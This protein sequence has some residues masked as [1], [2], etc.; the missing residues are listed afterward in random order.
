MKKILFLFLTSIA[1]VPCSAQW[2]NASMGGPVL[3]FGVH[4]TSLFLSLNSD[5]N[6]PQ[7]P[8]VWR[9]VS[10]TP[11]VVWVIADTGIDFSQG[12]VTSF[13]SLGKYFFAGQGS[14]PAN[15]STNNGSQWVSSGTASP[16]ATNGR[17]LFAQYVQPSQIVRST[18]SGRSW[19]AKTNLSVS[20]YA[21]IGIVIFANN[22]SAIWRSTDT[23]NNWSQIHPPFTG[24][25]TPMDSLLFIV[26]SGQLAESND[27][28]TNWT[29]VPVDSGGVSETVNAL[30]TD[31]KNLFAG[32]QRGVLVSTDVGKSWTAKND[33]LYNLYGAISPTVT[34]MIVFDTSLF[35]EV[36]YGTGKY[37]VFNRPISELI[38]PDS[39][40]SVVQLSPAVDSI[41]I[42]PNPS[43]GN[44]TII[45]GGTSIY[46]VS[47]LNVLGENV[48][49]MPNLRESEI[50]L[51]LS[52][53]PAGTYFLRV[54]TVN[55][56]DLRKVVIQH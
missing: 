11:N 12:D 39:T 27:S 56:S 20:S 32:T 41:E 29:T 37:Y 53:L 51:D 24:T 14:G 44:V 46:S 17:D 23:G 49:N 31:G 15:V 50:S 7:A 43:T 8:L 45:S 55:G 16:V 38:N 10:L 4:D 1:A 35:I 18:D 25:M 19:V 9:L 52:K 13:A 21:S 2:K 6:D 30:V 42:Y 33:S 22:G 54:E 34:Q 28:G 36:T 26:G 40:A 3:A 5:P 48:L 47:I